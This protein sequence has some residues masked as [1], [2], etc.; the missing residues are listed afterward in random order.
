MKKQY[1]SEEEILIAKILDKK[2]LCDTKNKVMYSDFLNEKEQAIVEKNIKFDNCFWFGKEE[3][4]DRKV[5]IFYPE[6]LSED[7]VK[8]S[9]ENIISVIRISLPNELKRRIWA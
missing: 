2:R 1:E 3:N 9:L 4:L 5:L 8:N 7:L 6:K